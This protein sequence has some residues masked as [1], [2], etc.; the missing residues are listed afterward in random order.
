[1]PP[2]AKKR[3][4]SAELKRRIFGRDEGRC[5][6]CGDTYEYDQVVAEHVI[7]RGKGGQTTLENLKIACRPCN[8]KKSDMSVE[9]FREKYG[10]GHGS[11]QG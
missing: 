11:I 4:A 6:L 5:Y 8:R 2:I 1:M 7:P 10:R 3:F 9:Q